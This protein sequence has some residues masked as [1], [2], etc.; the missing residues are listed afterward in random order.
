VNPVF[1]ALLVL[2]GFVSGCY[3]TFRVV[4]LLCRYWRENRRENRYDMGIKQPCFACG[5]EH[6]IVLVRRAP[7][8]WNLSGPPE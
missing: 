6:P 2:T 5:R 8:P 1:L 3:A 4:V 7:P